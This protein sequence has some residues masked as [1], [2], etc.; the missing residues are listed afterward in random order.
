MAEVAR[1]LRA[2]STDYVERRRG[3]SRTRREP[4]A[5]RGKRAAFALFYAPLHFLVVREIIRAAGLVRPVDTVVDLGCGTGAAG[6][7][8]SSILERPPGVIGVDRQGSILEEAAA[9]YRRFGSAPT[10]VRGTTV[11]VRWPR[12]P[13]GVVA[14]YTVNEL[15]PAER[16]HLLDR[17]LEPNPRRAAVLVVEPIAKS[18]APWWP[19][20]T[21]R[22]IEHGGQSGE[23]RFHLALPS[24]VRAL[25]RAARL[26]HR[27]QTARALWL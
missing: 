16:D 17:L 6:A 24:I 18:V 3:T 25:D 26:D 23:F 13:F 15:D 20:W 7:A 10:I 19:R 2:L 21:A 1:A 12:R 14:A 5:G 22:F 27:E 9:T 11:E 8:W 4:L